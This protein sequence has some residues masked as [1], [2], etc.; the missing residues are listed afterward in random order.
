[1]PFDAD[2]VDRSGARNDV[3]IPARTLVRVRVESAVEK[4]S[5]AGNEMV[6]VRLRVE[7]GPYASA[8]IFDRHTMTGKG[9][10][11]LA[12][13]TY[14]VGLKSWRLESERPAGTPNELE[15]RV[16]D[17]EVKVEAQEGYAPRNR[18]GRYLAPEGAQAGTSQ[19]SSSGNQPPYF[20][21]SVPF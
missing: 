6:E 17:V 11:F 19:V 4:V 20:D 8:S 2:K 1:M 16:C 3:L 21:D 10:V 14:A 5:Q 7:G 9:A 13:L 15:R 12:D 18:V